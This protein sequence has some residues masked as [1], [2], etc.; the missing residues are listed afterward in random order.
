MKLPSIFIVI[1]AI[2]AICTRAEDQPFLLN[3]VATIEKMFIELKKKDTGPISLDNYGIIIADQTIVHN[4]K[5]LKIRAALDLS[6]LVFIYPYHQIIHCGNM[7][8]P[9]LMEVVP[10]H[11]K[12]RVFDGDTVDNWLEIKNNN[13]IAIFLTKFDKNIFEWFFA[14]KNCII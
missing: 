4:K 13:F 10:P 11:P 5:T 6:G 1:L 2:L 7:D 14:Y 9:N 3:E 12:W 8:F